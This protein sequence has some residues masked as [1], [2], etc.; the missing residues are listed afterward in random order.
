MDTKATASVIAA[1]RIAAGDDRTHYD[2]LAVTLHWL[3]VLLVLAQFGLAETWGFAPRSARHL[4]IV[5]H[6]SFGM[7]LALVLVVRIAWRLLPGHQV[8]AAGSG[9]VELASKAVHYLLYGLLTAEA[10]LGFVLRWSGT[11]L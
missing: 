5:A 1:T 9:W 10:V 3:T 2:G 4:M 8:R 11:R 6:M 7:L